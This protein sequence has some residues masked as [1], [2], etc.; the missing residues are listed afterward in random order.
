MFLCSCSNSNSGQKEEQQ[1][2]TK[3]LSA[4]EESNDKIPKQL[5]ELENSIEDIIGKLGGPSVSEENKDKEND[6]KEKEPQKQQKDNKEGQEQQQGQQ[7]Q[8]QNNQDNQ[9][10][11]HQS[12]E[13]QQAKDIWSE[14]KP[15]IH[16]MHSKWNSYMPDAVKKGA[17]KKL[18]DN[19]SDSL[20]TLTDSLREKNKNKTLLLAS[21]LYTH[22]PDFYSLYKTGSSP[23]IKRIRHYARNVVLNSMTGNWE[24]SFDGMNSLKE[25]WDIYKNTID[26]EMQDV[27]G[28]LD[29]SIYE[30][31]KV[32][33]EKNQE[34]SYI[35]GKI[36]ISNIRALEKAI[37]ENKSKSKNSTND[38]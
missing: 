36:T 2:S 24:Q 38:G 25:T 5:E 7:D 16:E 28:K 27:S 31:N 17:N 8:Q 23:E 20:N 19:F 32:I 37:E 15:T 26:K 4:K 6:D 9:Q 3:Q 14:I 35:K 10:D 13:Q 30:L 12:E 34:L 21:D 18:V 22:I 11:E 1:H 29:F 33:N